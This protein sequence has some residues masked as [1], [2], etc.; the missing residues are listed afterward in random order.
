MSRLSRTAFAMFASFTLT[1][2]FAAQSAD[3]GS[4]SVPKGV[5]ASDWTSIRAAY[6]AGRHAAFAVD[7]GYQVRNPGQQWTTRFDGRGF[8]TQP[9]AGGWT[10]GLE[11]ERYG[12]AGAE[13]EATKPEGVTADGQRVA[14]TWD[15]TIEEWYIND[16]RG[17]EHGFTLRERPTAGE[18]G[19]GGALMLTLAVRGGLLPVVS[20]D[21][22]GVS[23]TD[24]NGATVLNYAGLIVFDADQQVLAARFENMDSMLV[25]S[26][27]E[28]AARYPLTIDPIAQQAYLKASNTD[29]QDEFGTSVAVSGDTV[30]VGAPSEDSAA[31][32]VNGNQA[33]DSLS[34]AGAAYVFTRSGSNWSQQAYLKASNPDL[35]DR[36]GVSVAVSGDTVV[37]GAPFERSAASGVNGNQADDSLPFAGAAYVFTRSGN[38]WSQQAYLKASNP[39]TNDEFGH[40]VAVSGDTVVVAAYGEDSAASGVNGSQANGLDTAGAAYVFNRHGSTWSQQAYLKASNPDAFDFF[41]WSV[42]VSGDTVVVGAYGED[43]AASGVNGNQANGLGSAG[44]AYVFNRSGSTWSQQAYLKASNPDANDYFGISVAVF[45]DTVVVGAYGEDSAASGVNGNQANGLGSAGAAYV[46]NRSG[47]T[48]SQQAYL[49]ASNPGFADD[50]GDSVAVSGDTV[51]VGAPQEASAASGVNGNQA[52]DS[53][54]VAGAAYVFTRTGTTWSQQ[55]YLK[56]SNPDAGDRFGTVVA[57]SDETIV[58]GAHEEDSAASGVNGD[59]ADDS[60]FAAGAAYVFDLGVWSNLGSGLAGVSGVPQL[61]GAGTLLKD[62]TGSLTLSN[63]APSAPAILLVSLSSTPV[64][65]YC[66]IVVPVPAISLLSFATP[67]SGVLPLAWPSW[68]AGFSGQSLYFQWLI[69]DAAA[70]CTVAFSNAVRG[71]VP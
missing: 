15:V 13:H 30:V 48:W 26:I 40:S 33:D 61:E 35:V 46:F 64:P 4:A 38:T 58:A 23:F 60:L 52:D 34:E 17:L 6:E 47:G 41:G 9:D 19:D 55:A 8:Q 25:L 16:A 27:D 1:A 44:A 18:S 62:S 21:G 63:A 2:S 5:S 45:G 31:S 39:D 28:R 50:F 49:K 56:A 12:F 54:P 42:A 32:G 36:F 29:A 37:V 11:L 59:E 3:D 57:V 67:A 22:R 70:P 68:P 66:G 43:S 71:D 65:A 24:G 20:D 10:W 14:Y 53:L 51:V 7:G 69:A